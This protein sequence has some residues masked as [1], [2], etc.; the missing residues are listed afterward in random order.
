MRGLERK[1]RAKELLDFNS[2][3]YGLRRKIR[4]K[5]EKN[6]QKKKKKRKS[7]EEEKKKK[8]RKRS[9]CS[10]DLEAIV[11]QEDEGFAGKKCE[12]LKLK[13]L[14]LVLL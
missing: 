3:K 8:K 10:G 13:L 4:E 12:W 1:E 14:L 2:R 9:L 11:K 5:E 7:R 6:R